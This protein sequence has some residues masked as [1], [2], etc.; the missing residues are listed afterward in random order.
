[1]FDGQNAPLLQLQMLYERVDHAISH[2]F[3]AM[4]KSLTKLESEIQMKYQE[5][6]VLND[7]DA[8]QIIRS[9]ER[10]SKHA[11]QLEHIDIT[12]KR[13]TT[14]DGLLAKSQVLCFVLF[15]FN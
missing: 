3:C 8:H 2:T 10:F 5:N 1:M 13:A 14:L 7:E 15:V 9:L 6:G 11:P 12:I 4:Q